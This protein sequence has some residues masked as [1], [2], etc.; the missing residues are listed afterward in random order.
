MRIKDEQI[1]YAIEQADSNAGF[2]GMNLTPDEKHQIKLALQEKKTL[3]LTFY[4]LYL[5]RQNR[6]EIKN[7]EGKKH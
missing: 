5:K 7:K 2:E 3:L 4:E 1:D 6:K